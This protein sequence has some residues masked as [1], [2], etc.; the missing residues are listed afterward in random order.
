MG[1]ITNLLT[2]VQLLDRLL[3]YGSMAV[4]AQHVPAKL[5]PSPRVRVQKNGYDCGPFVC[6][7]SCHRSLALTRSQRSKGAAKNTSRNVSSP[8]ASLRSAQAAGQSR[9]PQPACQADQSMMPAPVCKRQR[10]MS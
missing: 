8:A 9:S 3:Q 6:S 7:S 5:N 2:V 10:T 4:G 1:I